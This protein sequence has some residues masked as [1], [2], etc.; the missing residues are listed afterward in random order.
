MR[1]IGYRK[2]QMH[3]HLQTVATILLVILVGTWAL[4]ELI[5]FLDQ[6]E[7]KKRIDKIAGL[8]KDSGVRFYYNVSND[9]VAVCTESS[10]QAGLAEHTKQVKDGKQKLWDKVVCTAKP[11]FTFAGSE[12]TLRPIHTGLRDDLDEI[13]GKIVIKIVG[14]AERYTLDRDDFEKVLK[15]ILIKDSRLFV[16]Y[17]GSVPSA[18]EQF[19]IYGSTTLK[20]AQLHISY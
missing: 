17:S 12:Q 18:E 15:S 14:G 16:P 9:I 1:M 20:E 7:R 6:T 3:N 19:N 4:Q 8:L 11:T 13:M 5:E 2:C 10:F